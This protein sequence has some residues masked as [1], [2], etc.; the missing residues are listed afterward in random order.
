MITRSDLIILVVASTALLGGIYR[1]HQNTQAVNAVTIPA[2]SRST[3]QQ[4]SVNDSNAANGRLT[5]SAA[6]V[7]ASDVGVPPLAPPVADLD[8]SD[9]IAI[10]DTVAPTTLTAPTAAAFGRHVVS[11]GEYLGLIANRYGTSVNKLRSVNS[12]QGNLILVGQELL[13]PLPAP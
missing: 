2:N 13:Y 11:S 9:S 10:T 3:L 1:W 8:A 4:N 5:S 6:A 12:I 7:V